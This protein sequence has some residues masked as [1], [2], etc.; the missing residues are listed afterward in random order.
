LVAESSR[1][2]LQQMVAVATVRAPHGPRQ[3]SPLQELVLHYGG[4]R[5]RT[6]VVIAASVWLVTGAGSVLAVA[7]PTPDRIGVYFDQEAGLRTL[8]TWQ[9]SVQTIYIIVTNPTFAN[10][11]GWQA[12]I[13]GLDAAT[14]SVIGTTITGGDVITG[15]NV[16][17]DVTYETP[18]IAQPVTVLASIV[19]FTHDTMTCNCLVLTG[20]D[21]PAIP[22]MLPL[23]WAQPDQPAAMQVARL[24]PNG[25]AAAIN[26]NPI[27]EIASCSVV[28][29]VEPTSWSSLK[30][31]YR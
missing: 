28:V 14:V 22:E 18:L 15:P 9:P 10:I 16:Q 23:V 2:G 30:A 1:L 19:G 29:A 21:R 6:F 8:W 17:Y 24:Y 11:Y 26:E 13:R 7:D 20:I 4:S 12:A 31:L 3:P 25:V 27:P 5:M